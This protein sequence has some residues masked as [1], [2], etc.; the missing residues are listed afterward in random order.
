MIVPLIPLRVLIRTI[1]ADPKVKD[2]LRGVANTIVNYGEYL[3]PVASTWIPLLGPLIKGG[4][5]LIKTLSVQSRK[6]RF[7]KLKSRCH[8]P[9]R[10]LTTPACILIMKRK[11]KR[12]QTASPIGYLMNAHEQFCRD[13]SGRRLLWKVSRR[14][15]LKNEINQW[16]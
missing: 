3:A 10:S 4:N 11:K 2:Q 14:G 16:G 12:P 15:P 8:R 9:R 6:T 13:S 7:C 5:A 1:N